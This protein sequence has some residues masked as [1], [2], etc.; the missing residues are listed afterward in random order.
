MGK[1]GVL[2][3]GSK[4]LSNPCG[5]TPALSSTGAANLMVLMAQEAVSMVM[6]VTTPTEDLSKIS[7]ITSRIKSVRS[8]ILTHLHTAT[9]LFA[10]T[11][12]PGNTTSRARN[13]Q[14]P[15]DS[16]GGLGHIYNHLCKAPGSITSNISSISNLGIMP[17]LNISAK[18]HSSPTTLGI[19]HPLP[20]PLQHIICSSSNSSSSGLEVDGM[21]GLLAASMRYS[22]VPIMLSMIYSRA[23][24]LQ[25]R[26]NT[27]KEG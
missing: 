4:L 17:Q 9:M 7:H 19:H 27:D 24:L 26:I 3:P 2:H 21:Q 25:P 1:V 14:G 13:G 23:G 18:R 20:H 6:S 8:C 11:S 16:I 12:L 22:L 10:P 5:A 15:R